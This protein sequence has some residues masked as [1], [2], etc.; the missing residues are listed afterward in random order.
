M[1]H[2]EI[3][4]KALSPHR[5]LLRFAKFVTQPDLDPW[6]RAE[7][8]KMGWSELERRQR[9]L[10]GELKRNQIIEICFGSNTLVNSRSV[11]QQSLAD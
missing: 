10:I 8:V 7:A 5:A 2:L 6:S 1:A 9:A 11:P 3:P 4:R